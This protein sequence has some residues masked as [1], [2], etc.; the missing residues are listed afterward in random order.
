[1]AKY[2]MITTIKGVVTQL[3]RVNYMIN[4]GEQYCNITI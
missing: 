1:M 4:I 3:V 2:I